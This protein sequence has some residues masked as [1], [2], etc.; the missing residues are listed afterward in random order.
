MQVKWFKSLLAAV[1]SLS[2]VF[3]SHNSVAND[4]HGGEGEKG[5]PKEQKSFL[6]PMK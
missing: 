6:M 3:I 4:Q 1:F 5:A 2:L